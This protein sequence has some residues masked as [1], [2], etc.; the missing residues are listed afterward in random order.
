MGGKE[1]E[2]EREMDSLRVSLVLVRVLDLELA[3]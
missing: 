3:L 1:R 2:E